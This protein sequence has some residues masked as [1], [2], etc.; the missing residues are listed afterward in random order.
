MQPTQN[1]T[2]GVLGV[3]QNHFS[4]EIIILLA[5]QYRLAKGGV[6]GNLRKTVEDDLIL[7]VMHNKP[8]TKDSSQGLQSLQLPPFINLHASCLVNA[9]C[10]SRA[11]P[12]A[13]F[14]VDGV[15]IFWSSGWVLHGIEN[16]GE[17]GVEDLS[18][19]FGY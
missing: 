1:I 15:L 17:V 11:I 10:H 7:L 4:A 19:F 5:C 8:S 6:M 18:V 13:S 12:L 14:L 9:N 3:Y 2:K 16:V